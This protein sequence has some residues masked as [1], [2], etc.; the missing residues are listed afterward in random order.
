MLSV[1]DEEMDSR[2]SIE[3]APAFRATQ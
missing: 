3:Y 2:S 1:D